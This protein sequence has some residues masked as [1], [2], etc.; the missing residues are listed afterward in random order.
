MPRDT[1]GCCNNPQICGSDSP[2][3]YNL[4]RL[5]EAVIKNIII[6]SSGYVEANLRYLDLVKN[7]DLLNAAVRAL[8]HKKSALENLKLE[9]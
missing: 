4:Y 5:T 3:K 2:E 8:E 6:T 7:N 9:T 1:D